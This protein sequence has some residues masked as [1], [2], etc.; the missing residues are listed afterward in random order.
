MPEDAQANAAAP[1]RNAS[2]PADGRT[3]AT[4]SVVG[5]AA[6]VYFAG[7]SNARDNSASGAGLYGQAE[8][9]VHSQDSYGDALDTYGD[10][11]A[12]P[13]FGADDN[14]GSNGTMAPD[15]G[16]AVAAA[17]HASKRMVRQEHVYNDLMGQHASLENANDRATPTQRTNS[18]YS[19]PAA[20]YA[21]VA[22]TD[23]LYGEPDG[24]GDVYGEPT[25]DGVYG[26]PDAA[27]S[28]G[29]YGQLTADGGAYG[30]PSA[31]GKRLV[32]TRSVYGEPSADAATTGGGAVY[33]E[34]SAVTAATPGDAV[35][36]EPSAVSSS[37][38][39][40]SDTA[41]VPASVYGDSST[42]SS[43]ARPTSVY[44]EPNAV[45]AMGC[46]D[47]VYGEP[48][49]MTARSA[50][51]HSVYGEASAAIVAEG[52]YGGEAVV[53]QDAAMTHSVYGDASAQ[54]DA[55]YGG[56]Q[57]SD[58]AYGETAPSDSMFAV[59]GAAVA[60]ANDIYGDALP[61]PHTSADVYGD[62]MTGWHTDAV[63]FGVYGDVLPPSTTAGDVYGDVLPGAASGVPGS[64][65]GQ[66]AAGT[67]GVYWFATAQ[68]Q[69][70][71]GSDDLYDF[72]TPRDVLV[73]TG[74]GDT[75]DIYDALP[76]SQRN[77]T[78][79]GVVPAANGME[80][81]AFKEPHAIPRPRPRPRPRHS[82]TGDA[83]VNP[84]PVSI[85]AAAAAETADSATAVPLVAMEME[86]VSET[87]TESSTG[88]GARASGAT[89]PHEQ[90][91]ATVDSRQRLEGNTSEM[92]AEPCATPAVPAEQS[93]AAEDSTTAAQSKRDVSDAVSAAGE[94]AA[95]LAPTE[96]STPVDTNTTSGA[97]AVDTS[98]PRDN[99]THSTRAT[100]DT[101][102][103]TAPT[104]AAT[105][106]ASSNGAN[107]GAA[108]TTAAPT[109]AD[110][111]TAAPT[112]AAPTTGESGGEDEDVMVVYLE[113][114]PA[115]ANLEA[116]RDFYGAL[117]DDDDADSVPD[118]TADDGDA[119]DATPPPPMVVSLDAS[120]GTKQAH[121][122]SLA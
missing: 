115:Y 53:A 83:I 64:T 120:P 14:A 31:V 65:P 33:G 105:L 25:A 38:A 3:S 13:Q 85:A 32:T 10:A 7:D 116:I 78:S 108:T 42:V 11:P 75:Q 35:Y 46:V 90:T 59:H 103:A 34:P 107:H 54:V 87:A 56:T 50:Q 86:N 67:D 5:R 66:A 61:G 45:S 4:S 9:P 100:G 47:A 92:S 71:G 20:E 30:E 77:S 88:Q 84:A 29:A 49:T 26:D 44:G 15:Y 79:E 93:P 76:P 94:A 27:V 16:T 96:T 119:V 117:G 81:Y 37:Q 69:P 70:A 39:I 112:T 101:T 24:G 102:A 110:P 121:A 74:T 6:P 51:M 19:N 52:V 72:A 95:A 111:T 106:T 60:T 2:S 41:T 62:P 58:S 17:R 55:T 99:T 118:E 122:S 18:M 73:A 91:V 8:V 68:A 98:T 82:K 23:S 104:T 114:M 22:E 40:A 12:L 113:D 21:I 63:S 97:V 48:E 1:L 36:G 43:A 89:S 57:P 109:T 80:L 28:S